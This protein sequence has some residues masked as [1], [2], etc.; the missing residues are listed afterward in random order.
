MTRYGYL[1]YPTGWWQD[2]KG[3]MQPP[4]SFLDP[5]LRVTSAASAETAHPSPMKWARRLMASVRGR[6]A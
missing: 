4:G 1:Q 6:G 3:R 2:R 5:S